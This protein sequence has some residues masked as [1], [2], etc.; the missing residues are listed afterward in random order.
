M[1]PGLG[2]VCAYEMSV[3]VMCV[4]QSRNMER[5]FAEKCALYNRLEG[6]EMVTRV[7]GACNCVPC[8]TSSDTRVMAFSTVAPLE[9]L[10]A[11]R[12]N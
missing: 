8:A 1:L 11:F 5:T 4:V 10:C 6:K 2:A 7:A 3:K 9:T 12:L